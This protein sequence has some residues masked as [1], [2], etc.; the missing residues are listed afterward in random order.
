MKNLILLL[1]LAGLVGC[2]S[3]PIPK[4]KWTDKNM[5]VMIDPDS[6]DEAHYIQIQTALVRTG[7]FTVVDRGAALKAVKVEQERLHRDEADRFEDREKWAHWGKLFGVGSVI[8]AHVQCVKEGVW[9][10]PQLTTLFCKQFLSMVDSNTGEVILAVE[11]ENNSPT[12]ADRTYIAP[13]WKELVTQMVEEYPK[14]FKN[15]DYTGP[16]LQYQAVSEEHSKRQKEQRAIAQQPK[17]AAPEVTPA[18]QE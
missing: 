1:A 11:G 14:F 6:I 13:E 18:E 5:R 16:A 10:N 9:Y 12:S 7:K 8:V 15:E 3:A 17:A 2:A 4:T